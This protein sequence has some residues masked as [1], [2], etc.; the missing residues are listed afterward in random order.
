MTL[1]EIRKNKPDGATGYYIHGDIVLYYFK[2]TN[3]H[4]QIKGN[5]IEFAVSDGDLIKPLY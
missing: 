2:S 5:I 3:G 1:D 4:H